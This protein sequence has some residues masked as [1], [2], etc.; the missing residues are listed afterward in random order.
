MHWIIQT[1]F[2]KPD[3]P[4]WQHYENFIESLRRAGIRYT[5]VSIAPFSQELIPEITTEPNEHYIVFGSI[6]MTEIAYKRNWHPGVCN[7][8]GQFDQRVWGKAYGKLALNHDAA[9]LEFKNIPKFQGMVFLRPVHDFKSIT[10]CLVNWEWVYTQQQRLKSVDVNYRADRRTL[11]ADTPVAIASP[12]KLLRE[13]RFF[14]VD[15]KVLAGSQYRVDGEKVTQDTLKPGNCSDLITEFH[16]VAA[17]G[18]AEAA[19]EKY[20]PAS[21]Y[22]LDIAVISNG[23]GS[24]VCGGKFPVCKIIEINC[25]NHSGFYEADMSPVIKELEHYYGA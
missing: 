2:Y 21:A 7:Q 4:P 12:K 3:E 14:I 19:I 5:I 8:D 1:N 9:F 11:C 20:S 18:T 25:I 23:K 13:Y 17:L 16:G 24:T 22:S 6:A 10:G 15:G